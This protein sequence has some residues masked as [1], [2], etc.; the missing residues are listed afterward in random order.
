MGPHC[1]TQDIQIPKLFE[2]VMTGPLQKKHT[3]QTRSHE[4]STW[5]SG[6]LDEM[7]G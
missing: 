1:P 6:V 5:M 3:Y 2:D 7:K 4:V